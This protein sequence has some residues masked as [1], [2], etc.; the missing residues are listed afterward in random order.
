MIERRVPMFFTYKQVAE[1]LSINV[2]DVKEL[3]AEGHLIETRLLTR[4]RVSREH[5]TNFIREA[6]N[7]DCCAPE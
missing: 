1:I 6:A 4:W 2:C 5:L 3:I 7:E